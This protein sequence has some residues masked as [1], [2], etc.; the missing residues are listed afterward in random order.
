[1]VQGAQFHPL[2]GKVGWQTTIT[3]HDMV[4]YDRTRVVPAGIQAALRTTTGDFPRSPDE[5]QS[6][7]ARWLFPRPERAT[8]TATAVAARA[9]WEHRFHFR[10]EGLNPDKSVQRPGLRPPQIGALYAALAH[11]TAH[12]GAA[13][14]VTP[15]G[16]GKTE[17]ML[18]LCVQQRLERLLV[19][20]NDALRDQ[21]REKFLTLG[22][23]KD[24]GIVDPE[25][26]YPV[27]C[28]LKHIPKDGAQV[29]QLFLPCNVIV[30]TGS[31]QDAV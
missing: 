4:T 6:L 15:T 21:I 30:T 5:I 24:S 16:M 11:W 27:V 19:V 8:D 28:R 3:G 10:E 7:E 9:S 14:I 26:H 25:V 31:G 13:T 22:L 2:Q 17:T 23:R 20:P 18:A 12:E 1:M 29:D